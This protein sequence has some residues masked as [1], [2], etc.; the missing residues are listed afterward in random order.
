MSRFAGFS[1]EAGR[2]IWKATQGFE[3]QGGGGG[4]DNLPLDSFSFRL[5][6]TAEGATARSGVTVGAGTA[7]LCHIDATGAIITS[8][9][10]IDIINVA[11]SA[12]GTNRYIAVIQLGIRW[13]VI[14]EECA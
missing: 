4:G 7:V 10:A 2:R 5:A 14:W 8:T 13:M 12:V 11:A 6:Y 9:E 3:G 1:P